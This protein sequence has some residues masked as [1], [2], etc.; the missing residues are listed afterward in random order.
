[1]DPVTAT[2]A[3]AFIGAVPVAAALIYKLGRDASTPIIRKGSS[4]KNLHHNYEVLDR[5]LQKLLALATDIDHGRVNN[6]EIKNTSTYKLWITRVWEIQAE[7]E[8]LVNEYERIKE[9]FRREIN[10]IA[11]G[12]LSKKMVNKLQEIRQHIEEG[13]FLIANL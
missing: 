12:K 13:K 3:G 4:I 7:V 2:L 5:E 9:K 1:M 11:K 6:Q 8:A 10:V